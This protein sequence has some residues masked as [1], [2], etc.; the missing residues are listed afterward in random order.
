[1]FSSDTGG[2]LPYLDVDS[3]GVWVVDDTIQ[4]G[5]S[6]AQ[7]HVV[8][9]D[10]VNER[11]YFSQ[12]ETTGFESFSSGE[13]VTATG[14]GTSTGAV[15]SGGQTNAAEFDRYSGEILYIEN[16]VPVTRTSSQ[17]EDIKLVVRY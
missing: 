1:M 15:A 5:S 3:G 9:Y 7:A 16:R 13:S 4:G 14:A 2:A 12:D 11:I 8:S 6:G 17:T 10:S